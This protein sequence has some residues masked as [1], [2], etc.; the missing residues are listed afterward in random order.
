M[1]Q[2][3][4]GGGPGPMRHAKPDPRDRAQLEESPVSVRRI[5]AL[6]APYRWQV[7]LVVALIVVSSVITLA[8]PFLV[9]T[10][11]DHAIPDQDVP[12]LLGAVGAMLAVTVVASILGV[13]QTWIST[14]VGQHVM[15]DLRTRV[16][17]HL[18]RQSLG[19]FT[20]TRGGEIQSRLTNDIGG[21]QNVV[22]S[23]A[24]SIA[25]NVTTVVG[26]AVAMAVLS[27]RLSLLSLL[28]LPPA[29]WLTRKVALMRREI[30]AVRQRRLADMQTQI[31]ESLSLSGV[32][33]GKTL[34]TGPA[35]STRFART[36]T[37]L[38][39]LEVRSQLSG[40]W[41]M[42]TMNIVFAAIPALLYLVAGLPA[43]SGGMTIGTLVAFT[44]LQA[45]LF[46]PLM[47]LLDVGVSV[48]GSLALFSRIFE[49]LD[50][51]V[52]IGEP[53]NPVRL[54]L[55]RIA[56]AVRFDDVRFRY[57]GAD[58]DALAG[59][60]LDVPAG[61]HVA[62]VGETG[63]G[64]T[65]LGSLVARLYDPTSGRVT[66]DGVD[67][68]DLP[69][70]DIA[71]LVGVVS[72]ETYLLHATVRENLRHAKPDAT[73]AEIEQAARAAHIHELLSSLPDGYDTVVG[74]RGHRFSGGEKQRL[75]I[76]RTLLRDPRI[77]VLDEATSALDNETE[78][79]VQQALD[80]ARRGR[81]TLTVAH[82]LSTIR[83]ADT[84]VVLD[85]GRIVEQ[86]SHDELLARGGRY[87][88][89]AARTEPQEVG[90]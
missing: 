48:T 3:P 21:M 5:G 9:R 60:T 67:V 28:V 10:L 51:T 42:A 19:F 24:T 74:A 49:Y 77:L 46:R 50:L 65:T 59:I 87:A 39:D 62:L 55:D 17:D 16:F 70:A 11:I 86:G 47:S 8:N 56:G 35:M 90:V 88:A 41:R 57:D 31:E 79:A 69:L 12:L 2:P 36:S 15:H 54:D 27:W 37:E 58:R 83:D 84:I 34:G 43:T 64:K 26:T 72:Q 1:M 85:R 76:A 13:V 73:D 89:L 6:F 80:A 53:A 71:S 25:A 45:T 4:P 82:R 66:I 32:L 44:G 33:L 61:S 68:R 23:T 78:R 18:Q 38:A 30:T 22:T 52:E 40:R 20:R 75:A 29:I 14:T 7:A 63:S 81:T